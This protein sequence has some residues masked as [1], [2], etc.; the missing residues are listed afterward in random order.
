MFVLSNMCIQY[1]L[2]C[3]KLTDFRASPVLLLN[4]LTEFPKLLLVIC[5]G[6]ERPPC[7]PRARGSTHQRRGREAGW[8]GHLICC[9]LAGYKLSSL[10][11]GKFFPQKKLE[12][13]SSGKSYSKIFSNSHFYLIAHKVKLRREVTRS[14]VGPRFMNFDQSSDSVSALLG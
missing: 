10:R 8:S 5:S 6:L 4:S 14:T 2:D 13:V 11:Q 9:C 1:R 7:Q 12:Q 3:K